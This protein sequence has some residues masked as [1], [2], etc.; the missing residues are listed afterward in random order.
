MQSQLGAEESSRISPWTILLVVG[1]LTVSYGICSDFPSLWTAWSQGW[2]TRP[3]FFTG[4]VQS[5]VPSDGLNLGLRA[6]SLCHKGKFIRTSGLVCAT[7]DGPCCFVLLM[8]LI[9]QINNPTISVR[10]FI[11]YWEGN[12][13]LMISNYVFSVSL[14]LDWLFWSQ[15]L[16]IGSSCSC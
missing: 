4:P 14:S 10:L 6:C 12:R 3:K 7:V 5:E 8:R 16:L 9:I 1:M 2:T 13:D 15:C 11:S